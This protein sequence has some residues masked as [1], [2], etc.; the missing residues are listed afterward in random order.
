MRKV[1]LA[2]TALVAMSV[3]A[4]QADITI[5]GFQQ[6]EITDDGSATTWVNDGS[7]NITSKSTTD[8]G[9][10]ITAG[11]HINTTGDAD[12]TADGDQHVDDSYLDISGEFGAIR[13]GNTDDALDRFDGTNPADWAESGWGGVAANTQPEVM[14]SYISPSISG[15]TVYGSSTA[16]GAASG[17]GIS[18]SNGPIKA[19]YQSWTSG[20]QDNTMM[21]I[22]FT[23]A[24]ATIGFSTGDQ[25][26]A[27]TKT[28]SSAMG[29]TYSVNDALSVYYTAGKDSKADKTGSA[30]GGYYTIA[31]GLQA[32]FES[33]DDGSADT[34]T[35]AHLK[36]SF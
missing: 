14:A 3:T 2:T 36:V 16:E 12:N 24:G 28:E 31:P 25:D 18:Y 9:L 26:A 19:T 33:M 6:F 5:S 29:V 23:M 4:A 7:V 13:L 35:Y 27:G 30:I 10:T 21:A 15:V 34:Q 22:N 1:L 20:T 11:H 8:S 17:V 32:A